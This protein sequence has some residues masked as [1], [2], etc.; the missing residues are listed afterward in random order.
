MFKLNDLNEL[1]HHLSRLQYMSEAIAVD[2]GL[3]HD[4][5]MKVGFAALFYDFGKLLIDQ[6][7]FNAHR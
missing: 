3:T 7:L 2:I 5:D 6:D 4:E 1:T